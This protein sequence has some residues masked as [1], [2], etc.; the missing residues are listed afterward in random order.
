MKKTLKQKLP[1]FKKFFLK[2][3]STK[4]ILVKNTFWLISAEIISKFFLFL[5]TI[6]II[7]YLGVEMYGKFSYAIAFVS[8]FGI[9]VDFGLGTMTIQEISGN[10]QK[11]S[12]FFSSTLKLK[13]FLAV[14]TYLLIL[15]F[16]TA[17]PINED[18]R[19]FIYLA[20][21]YII[22]QSF[23]L[24]F[25]SLFQAFEKMEINFFARSGYTFLLLIFA[26]II[27]FFHFSPP[28]LF[29]AYIISSGLILI[30]SIYF[31]RRF[32]FSFS[33]K[34]GFSQARKLIHH[35]WPLFLGYVFIT[36]YS[37]I[38][39]IILKAFKGYQEV[40]LY[41]AGYK[42]LYAFLIIN[43]IHSVLFP[44]IVNLVT[45]N[46]KGLNRLL[47]VTISISFVGI[48]I[49][50]VLIY[51]LR[52]NIILLIYGKQYLASANSMFILLVGG[53]LIYFSGF[54]FN[55]LLA[56]KQQ[57]FWAFSLLLGLIVNIFANLILIPIYGNIG[58]AIAYCLGNFSILVVVFL[59]T[60][61][62]KE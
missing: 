50:L 33:F 5:V 56:K 10:R 46:P 47:K 44:R 12:A 40:G 52:K 42:I 20:G 4:Q 60:K 11:A 14:L 48:S 15:I 17:I 36:S 23:V 18:V 37:Y 39:T 9:L 28:M 55:L 51:F 3:N 49:A 8:L 24:L 29:L 58:A 1:I 21:L 41:Q 34:L 57:L 54:F 38:D 45:N 6:S 13:V 62:L 25:A 32:L 22:I 7:R 35:S 19:I 16:A 2:N 61:T 59:K 53:S 27:I 43:I 30:I 26:V 31:V